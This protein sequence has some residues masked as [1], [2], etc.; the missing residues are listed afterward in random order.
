MYRAVFVQKQMCSV[1]VL[2]VA[3]IRAKVVGRKEVSSGN[4][5]YGDPIKRIRYD[6][7]QIKV[8]L[9]DTSLSS[10]SVCFLPICN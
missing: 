4:D 3:V 7:K 9:Y 8:S 5:V 6:L 2:F 1:C 10:L